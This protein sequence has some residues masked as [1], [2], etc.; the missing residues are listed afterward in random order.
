MTRHEAITSMAQS[1]L[2]C[3]L[4]NSGAKLTAFSIRY[5]VERCGDLVKADVQEENAAVNELHRRMT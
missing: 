5:A 2:R 3:E 4:A 1:L